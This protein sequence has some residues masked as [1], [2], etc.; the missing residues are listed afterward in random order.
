MVSRITRCPTCLGL[1]RVPFA[2]VCATCDG[3]G[4]VDAGVQVH[5]APSSYTLWLQ[6]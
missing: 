6:K 3:K 5:P 4:T 1:G 2:K